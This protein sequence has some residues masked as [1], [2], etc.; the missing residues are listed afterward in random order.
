[1][2]GDFSGNEPEP[3]PESARKKKGDAPKS[4]SQDHDGSAPDYGAGVGFGSGATPPEVFAF[5]SLVPSFWLQI[6]CTS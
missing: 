4:A 5:T 1:M 3:L 2:P 6:F